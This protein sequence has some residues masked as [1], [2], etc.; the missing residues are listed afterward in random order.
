MRTGSILMG[1]FYALSLV[2]FFCLMWFINEFH[3]WDK[4]Q[5]QKQRD[6]KKQQQKP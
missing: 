2:L 5:Q 1:C 3:K 4:Q 6:Y